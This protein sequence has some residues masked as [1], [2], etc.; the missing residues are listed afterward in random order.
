[1]HRSLLL[2]L[3]WGAS[4]CGPA[5]L[6]GSPQDAFDAAQE[7]VD[8]GDADRALA[9]LDQAADAGHLAA[10]GTRAEAYEQGYLTVRNPGREGARY[11]TVQPLPGQAALARRAYERTLADSVRAGHPPALLAA[12][13]QLAGPL[14]IEEGRQVSHAPA[15]DLDS[16]AALYR[17]LQ[18]TDG[19]HLQVAFLATALRDEDGRRRHLDAAVT[20]GEP[21]ACFIKLWWFGDRPDTATA[22]GMAR[23][24]DTIESTC[25]KSPGATDLAAESM[26]TL[27]DQ[28]ERGNEAAVQ[29]LDSLRVEGVFERHPR[30]AALVDE[31]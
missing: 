29:F 14:Y 25:P 16:A 4:A 3:V 2:V 26:R 7:A 12:A 13:L 28:V 5:P 18:D 11:V 9:L 22:A 21:Q 30:L 19:P 31:A 8:A 6:N 17:R 23:Y 24:L 27:T 15:A 10:L 1:M 20:A